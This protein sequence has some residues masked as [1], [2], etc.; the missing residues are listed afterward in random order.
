MNEGASWTKILDSTAIPVEGL[1]ADPS[2]ANHIFEADWW[3][4]ESFD[5]GRHWSSALNVTKIQIS[6]HD[7]H[8][9][10]WYTGEWYGD[11]FTSTNGGMIWNALHC[12]DNSIL[13]AIVFD[14][15][16]PCT[17]LAIRDQGVF[18]STDCGATWT[19]NML[20]IVT[21]VFSPE[22]FASS[23]KI[24]SI[25]PNPVAASSTVLVEVET[26][27]RS[28]VVVKLYDVLGRMV[29]ALPPMQV[30]SGV[31]MLS[32]P[33]EGL[34]CGIYSLHVRSGYS[35]QVKRIVIR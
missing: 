8:S 19:Q 25:F 33:I 18:E 1:F 32:F 14:P 10:R 13:S 11:I 21:D 6:A 23:M 2:N 7:W 22:Q 17:V 35:E 26:N 24:K 28:A 12:P 5:G 3:I 20:T 4:R 16:N 31:E 34:S 15:K 9:G 29:K 27:G 30:T